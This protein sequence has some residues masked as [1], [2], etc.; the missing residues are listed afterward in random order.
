[1][2]AQVPG[3]GNQLSHLVKA[4]DH[5]FP[6]LYESDVLVT[7]MIAELDCVAVIAQSMPVFLSH[8]VLIQLQSR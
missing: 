2:L 6:L 5:H 7:A 4:C 8:L 3:S 1:M